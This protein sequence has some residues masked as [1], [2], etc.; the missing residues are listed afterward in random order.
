MKKELSVKELLS[1]RVRRN[2]LLSY[3]EDDEM[4]WFPLFIIKANGNIECQLKTDEHRDT[5]KDMTIETTNI[6]AE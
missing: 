1:I 3:E 2:A 4:N 6:E 5:F